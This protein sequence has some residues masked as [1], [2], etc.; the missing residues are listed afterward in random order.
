[1]ESL[2]VSV[3]GSCPR[4]MGEEMEDAMKTRPH[5]MHQE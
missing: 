4:L 3:D 1:M 2:G 5:L